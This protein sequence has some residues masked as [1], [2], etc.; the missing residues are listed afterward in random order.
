MRIKRTLLG[1][2]LLLAMP[3]LSLSGSNEKETLAPIAVDPRATVTIWYPGDRREPPWQDGP[4]SRPSVPVVEGQRVPIARSPDG[5]CPN[6]TVEL[7]TDP[8]APPARFEDDGQHLWFPGSSSQTSEHVDTERC[9]VVVDEAKAQIRW[10]RVPITRPDA[11]LRKQLEE[12]GLKIP[13][14]APPPSSP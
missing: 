13:V 7:A 3:A 9:E 4:R 10:K 11:R 8:D 1:L 2:G 6:V 12:S 5:T 14:D